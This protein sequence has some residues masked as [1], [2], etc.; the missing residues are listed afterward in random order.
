[1]MFFFTFCSFLKR[2]VLGGAT[3]L[4]KY[5]EQDLNL[6]EEQKLAI[7]LCSVSTS[8]LDRVSTYQ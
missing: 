2:M 1:M 7:G 3:A 5:A 8:V 4:N 6:L